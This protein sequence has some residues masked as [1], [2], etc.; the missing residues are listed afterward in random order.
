[1]TTTSALQPVAPAERIAT[2]DALR[3][4]ALLGILL[5]NMEAFG[6]PMDLAFTGIDPRWQ[7]ADH[8]ADALVY[9][10]VQGKFFTLFSLLFGMGFA[11]MAQRAAAAGREFS[12]LYLRRSLV[13]LCIGLAHAL[14]VWSG[15]I[16]VAYA[17]LSLFLPPFREAPRSWLPALGTASYLAG[18]ALMLVLAALLS[19]SALAPE[20]AEQGV[21]LAMQKIEAQR[22]AY[23]HGSWSEAFVQ[24]ARDVAAALQGLLVVGPEIFG[25]FL[26]GAWFVRSGAI[27][28]PERHRRL[29]ACLRWVALP[30]GLALMLGSVWRDPWLA[31]GRFDLPLA[32]TY[33]L[34]ALAGLLMCLGYLGWL[35]RWRAALRWLAPAGRMALTNYVAQSLVCTFVFYGYGLGWFERMPRAWQ[36]P[37][38]AALFVV[39][40]LLSHCWL[41][42]FQFGPLEWLWRAAT[43]LRWPPMRRRAPAQA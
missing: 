36:L 21:V 15:D 42:R 7:G 20:D 32:A 11:V 1:M 31:P 30:L 40:V 34:S 2:L 24:R 16:L 10:F 39:Q 43:Y 12:P 5:M 3:G 33:A 28:D 8:W 26:L 14:L 18:P 38:A 6:G 35:V 13:L 25:M 29:F 23:G 19:L 22:Q 37:F 17:L 9:V 27:A 4:F 41:R